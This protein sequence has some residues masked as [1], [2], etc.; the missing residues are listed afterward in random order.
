[1][2]N[3]IT[4]ACFFKFKSLNIKRSKEEI[5]LEFLKHDIALWRKDLQK[6]MASRGISRSS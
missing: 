1:M 6:E 3:Y 5:F 4:P 2:N